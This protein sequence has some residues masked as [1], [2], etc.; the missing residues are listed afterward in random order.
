MMIE[1]RGYK[2]N[3]SRGYLRGEVGMQKVIEIDGLFYK[4]ACESS[5]S[6]GITHMEPAFA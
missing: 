5:I 1:R 2:D 3:G 4:Y 6:G